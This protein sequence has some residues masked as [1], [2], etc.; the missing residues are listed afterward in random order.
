[1]VL[2]GASFVNIIIYHTVQIRSSYSTLYG[3]ES[4]ELLYADYCS[5]RLSRDRGI[6]RVEG[7]VFAMPV[8]IVKSRTSEQT[9]SDDLSVFQIFEKRK[10]HRT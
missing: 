5:V 1:M 9:I 3:R 10:I 7:C 2:I 4:R 6:W 8:V